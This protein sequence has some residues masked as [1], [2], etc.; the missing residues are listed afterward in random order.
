[1]HKT[2][3]FITAIIANFAALL[4]FIHDSRGL[5]KQIAD[6]N[7][8]R[9]Q[10]PEE[11]KKTVADQTIVSMKSMAKD[12]FEQSSMSIAENVQSVVSQ[13]RHEVVRLDNLCQNRESKLAKKVA[14]AE[15]AYS[16]Y[17]S[18]PSNEV[19]ILYLQIAIRK[20]PSELRYIKSMWSVVEKS[21]M[22]AGLIQEYQTMLSYCLDEATADHLPE[23]TML[24]KDLRVAVAKRKD[25]ADVSEDRS[26]DETRIAELKEW[27]SANDLVPE[28]NAHAKE[29]VARRLEILDM[30]AV[31]DEGGDYDAERE[32]AE[33]IIRVIDA[34]VR[35]KGFLRQ[36]DSEIARIGRINVSSEEEL[37]DVLSGLGAI[38]VAQP[39][40]SAQQDVCALYGTVLSA[41]HTNAVDVCKKEVEALDRLVRDSF[42][43]VDKMKAEKINVCVDG[44]DKALTDAGAAKLT[45]RL[46]NYEK[47]GKIISGYIGAISDPVISNGVLSRQLEILKKAKEVQ[48]LRMKKYQEESAAEMREIAKEIRKYKDEAWRKEY[49]KNQAV[50]LLKRLVKIDPGLLV[51]EIYELYQYEY[52]QLTADFNAWIEKE[53]AYEYKA[54]FMVE[55]EGIEKNKLE[56][57]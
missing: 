33:L 56:D 52:S 5:R 9:I 39:I 32:S 1:M 40:S 48:R 41:R 53:K 38:M 10:L 20:N 46:S 42:R 25:S 6:I 26:D 11:F 14:D 55:L 34:A 13:L 45:A 16:R 18:D 7:N 29:V 4:Y 19:A 50:P 43:K 28:F 12:V 31:L 54:E 21:G 27:L 49:K 35:I 8:I 2:I 37:R 22:D 36:A 57:L 15:F 51:P 47:Q 3:V 17:E 44:I 24:V 23:L 30:L